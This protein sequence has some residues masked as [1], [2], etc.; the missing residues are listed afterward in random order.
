M[1]LLSQVAKYC[2]ESILF[3]VNAI[4]FSTS[5]RIIFAGYNDFVDQRT[6]IEE[7]TLLNLR[8]AWR[9]SGENWEFAV[10]GKN[11]T[12]EEYIQHSYVIGP[13][14]IGTWGAPRTYGATVT[15][16]M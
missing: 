10:W 7:Y 3:G 9:S 1:S 4:D 5:G 2:K 12:E 6:V 11:L 8:A 14:V 15:W 13:G 16:Q